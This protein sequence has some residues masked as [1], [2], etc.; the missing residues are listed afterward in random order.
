MFIYNAKKYEERTFWKFHHK[1]KCSN[2]AD[3]SMVTSPSV[4]ISN[5]KRACS[6]AL[7]E[8]AI[9]I[10]YRIFR[11][12]LFFWDNINIQVRYL[13][14]YVFLFR[15]MKFLVCLFVLVTVCSAYPQGE[16]AA[17]TNE[18][19]AQA[20]NTFLIPKDAEIQNVRLT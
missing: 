8:R 11:L 12:T 4:Y 1:D 10:R 15:I 6:G 17:F 9:F 5:T 13:C 16:G 18:A 20:Q 14:V 2:T 19:I 3:G 7:S